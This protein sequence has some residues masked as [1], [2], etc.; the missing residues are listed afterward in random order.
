MAVPTIRSEPATCPNGCHQLEGISEP[1]K[2]SKSKLPEV[3]EFESTTASVDAIVDALKVTG[4]VILRN[5]LT[6]DK[7][8]RILADV[9]PYL[10]ADTPW[11]DGNQHK[12]TPSHIIRRLLMAAM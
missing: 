12:P 11:E 10:D 1:V 9:N 8:D 7:I 5:F 6:V 4:G 3:Q 2:S